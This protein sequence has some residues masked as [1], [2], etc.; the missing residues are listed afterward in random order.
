MSRIDSKVFV[1]S[2]VISWTIALIFGWLET[3]FGI[4]A[5]VASIPAPR[6][7][8]VQWVE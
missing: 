5:L 1:V 3:E 4:R 7:P 2:V 8:L 6:F